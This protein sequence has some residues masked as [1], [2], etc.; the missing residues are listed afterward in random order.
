MQG[1]PLKVPLLSPETLIGRRDFGFA[2]LYRT[3]GKPESTHVA[4]S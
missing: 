4:Y 2:A 3:S 1:F